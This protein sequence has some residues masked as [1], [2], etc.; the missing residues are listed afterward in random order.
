M[1]S[2][3]DV[4]EADSPALDVVE[5]FAFLDRPRLRR[6]SVRR[7]RMSVLLRARLPGLR[8]LARFAGL[9]GLSGLSGL[10]GRNSRAGHF[11]I[12]WQSGRRFYRRPTDKES[13]FANHRPL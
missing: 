2:S 1:T 12:L 6:H 13:R 10:R 8:G 4:E 7:R 11:N 3:V 5:R 9:S